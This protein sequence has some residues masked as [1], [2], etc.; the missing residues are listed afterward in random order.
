MGRVPLG[1]TG[2][3]AHESKG[4]NRY[5]TRN[6]R[7][8]ALA[9]SRRRPFGAYSILGVAVNDNKET[10]ARQ[11]RRLCAPLH[12]DRNKNEPFQVRS[13]R[14]KQFIELQA[15]RDLLLDDNLRAKYDKET[16]GLEVRIPTALQKSTYR[17]QKHRSCLSREEKKIVVAVTRER[18][19]LQLVDG[20]PLSNVRRIPS[21]TANSKFKKYVKTNVRN[22]H[23]K[24]EWIILERA[25]TERVR[26][27]RLKRFVCTRKEDVKR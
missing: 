18:Q 20:L 24:H 2:E 5:S 8:I 6:R 21:G 15:A 12:P 3:F 10:I 25:K 19:R 11:F 27:K 13:A 16:L 14:T 22:R 23:T 1:E 26:D 4:I 7:K 9:P 17:V